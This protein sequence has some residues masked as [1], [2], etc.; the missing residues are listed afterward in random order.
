MQYQNKTLIYNLKCNIMEK[1]VTLLGNEE[2][3]FIYGGE[4]KRTYDWKPREDKNPKPET[5]WTN[6]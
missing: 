3:T 6:N 1:I 2:Q 4:I 5:Q